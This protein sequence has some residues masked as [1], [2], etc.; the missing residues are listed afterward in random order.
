MGHR[1]VYDSCTK[2]WATS[3]STRHGQYKIYT[4]QPVYTAIFSWVILPETLGPAGWLS[5]ALIG[6]AV[7]LVAATCNNGITPLGHMTASLPSS[8]S[9]YSIP[10]VKFGRQITRG[11]MHRRCTVVD[12]C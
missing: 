5:G 1:R 6:A 8:S 12:Y 11:V 4:F 2:L 10:N 3:G 9:M 7:L